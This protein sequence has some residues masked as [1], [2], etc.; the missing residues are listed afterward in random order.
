MQV[1]GRIELRAK[2]DGTVACVEE[3]SMASRCNAQLKNMLYARI[4]TVIGGHIENA[5]EECACKSDLGLAFGGRFRPEGPV[6][7]GDDGK[8]AA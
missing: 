6:L 1:D 4:M 3:L 8:G 2:L 5:I 7:Q